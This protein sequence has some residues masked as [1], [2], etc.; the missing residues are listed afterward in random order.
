MLVVGISCQSLIRKIK[1]M[2]LPRIDVPTDKTILPISQKEIKFRPFLVKEEKMVILSMTET[3]HAD[4]MKGLLDASLDVAQNCMLTPDVDV[5]QLA[6]ADFEWY[7][8]Q[9]RKASKGAE[10][11]LKIT[12]QNEASCGHENQ[13]QYNLNDVE[14]TDIGERKI[15]LTDKIGLVMKY[16]TMAMV[17]DSI[18]GPKTSNAVESKMLYNCIHQIFDGDTV[19]SEFTQ[20]ELDEFIESFSSD[21]M[22]KIHVFFESIPTI[23]G[24]ILITCDEC[25]E[26]TTLDLKGAKDFFV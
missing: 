5:R 7:F 19:T 21:M 17:M 13:Y 8:V 6:V 20:E 25:S 22:R 10:I 23:I 12:C 4:Q 1:T 9:L 15:M 16:P 24:K 26:E 2:A 3:D 11:P 14:M 18:S